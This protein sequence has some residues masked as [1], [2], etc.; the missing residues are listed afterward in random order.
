M[1]RS[2]RTSWTHHKKGTPYTEKQK[3]SK[4]EKKEKAFPKKIEKW[5][6][7]GT[8]VYVR[9]ETRKWNQ[10]QAFYIS[11][12][13]KFPF[14][15]HLLGNI[16]GFV[17]G[18]NEDDMGLEDDFN[19]LECFIFT[20]GESNL[21]EEYG[22]KEISDATEL[23]QLYGHEGV[24]PLKLVPVPESLKEFGDTDRILF[25]GSFR[26]FHEKQPKKGVE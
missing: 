18:M 10:D 26:E 17:D 5:L 2:K 3:I 23:K 22:I 24:I 16:A 21:W 6:E 12:G 11:H 9:D 4:Q 8:I 15:N 20:T 7:N 1:P 25:A 19:D 13:D 14:P